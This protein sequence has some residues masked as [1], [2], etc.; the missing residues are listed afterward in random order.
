M[1]SLCGEDE[2]DEGRKLV[3][4]EKQRATSFHVSVSRYIV[5]VVSSFVEIDVGEEAASAS[6]ASAMRFGDGS[7]ETKD[8]P[9]VV[10]VVPVA[11]A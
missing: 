4:T 8:R 9:V 10:V 3:G 5:V 11:A 6:F 1:S 7:Q 2:T